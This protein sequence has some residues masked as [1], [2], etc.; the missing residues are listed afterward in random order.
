[1]TSDRTNEWFLSTAGNGSGKMDRK[2]IEMKLSTLIRD[3]SFN[4]VLEDLEHLTDSKLLLS[5]LQRE[6]LC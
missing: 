4:H 5:F 3:P 6:V 2:V 1:M